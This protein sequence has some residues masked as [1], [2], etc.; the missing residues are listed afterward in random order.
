MES[1]D[2]RRHNRFAWLKDMLY[3]AP[4]YVEKFAAFDYLIEKS[5]RN[6]SRHMSS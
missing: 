1:G 4:S 5:R 3:A 2:R 6:R